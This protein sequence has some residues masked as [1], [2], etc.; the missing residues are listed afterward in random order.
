MLTS[1]DDA[2]SAKE[3]VDNDVVGVVLLMYDAG[4][5]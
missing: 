1:T 5:E 3:V 4:E 2:G